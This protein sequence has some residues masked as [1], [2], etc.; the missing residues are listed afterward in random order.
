MITIILDRYGN[1]WKALSCDFDEIPGEIQG[2]DAEHMYWFIDSEAT[3]EK[4]G[5]VWGQGNTPDEAL[6]SL[7]SWLGV[8][9]DNLMDSLGLTDKKPESKWSNVTNFLTKIE[10]T[11]HTGDFPD[12]AETLTFTEGTIVIHRPDGTV[13]TY[14][15]GGSDGSF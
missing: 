7:R 2:G 1:G 12:D 14:S 6:E 13:E 8:R 3:H 5:I 10:I 9:G 15:S 11:P 4:D